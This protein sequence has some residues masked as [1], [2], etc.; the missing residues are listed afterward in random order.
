MQHLNRIL[1]Q[2]L[3]M[4]SIL[5]FCTYIFPTGIYEYQINLLP[6]ATDFVILHGIHVSTEHP[7]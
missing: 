5:I 7:T 2:Y 3:D 4:H 1:Q 6:P